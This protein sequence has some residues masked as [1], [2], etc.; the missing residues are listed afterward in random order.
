MGEYPEKI[1]WDDDDW[2]WNRNF[3]SDNLYATK[4]VHIMNKNEAKLLRKLKKDT[5]LSEEEIRSHK[6]YRKM[7]SDAQVAGTKSDKT[8]LEKV[9]RD[10]MKEVTR[11]LKLAKEHPKCIE[12]FNEKVRERSWH[13]HIRPKQIKHKK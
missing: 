2:G 12:L 10:I 3:G 6:K 13:F 7:L 1:Y 8:S 5:G 9:E 11:E 4:G